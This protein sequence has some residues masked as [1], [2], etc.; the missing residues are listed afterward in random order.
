[1]I[2]RDIICLSHEEDGRI[3]DNKWR[4]QDGKWQVFLPTVENLGIFE[5]VVMLAVSSKNLTIS[6]L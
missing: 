4:W 6:R 1:M 5:L 3:L 2:D